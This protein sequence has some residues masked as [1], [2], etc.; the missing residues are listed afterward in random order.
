M[1]NAR[2]SL[3]TWLSSSSPRPASASRNASPQNG[4]RP[5]SSSYLRPTLTSKAQPMARSPSVPSESQL[6]RAPS[7]PISKGWVQPEGNFERAYRTAYGVVMQFAHGA[8]GAE[9]G[10]G[11]DSVYVDLWM[12]IQQAKQQRDEA[13]ARAKDMELKWM[14][15]AR[16]AEYNKRRVQDL[17]RAAKQAAKKYSETIA[18]L[19]EK[20]PQADAAT[21]PL[22]PT[23]H[24]DSQAQTDAPAAVE[25]AQ[26]TQV[27]GSDAA[28]QVA[29]EHSDSQAQTDVKPVVEM[30]QQTPEME[31][32][33]AA[34]QVASEMVEMA[35]QTAEMKGSDAAAQAEPPEQSDSQAQTDATSVVE[36]VEMAQQTTDMEGS[37][38]AVQVA[39]EMVEMAQQTAELKGSDAAVQVATEPTP[40]SDSQA[41]TDGE[42]GGGN[43]PSPV[44]EMV[45]KAQQTAE[46][47]K[48]ASDAA[49]KVA[50]EPAGEVPE[51]TPKVYSDSQAQ[52]D[53]DIVNVSPAVEMVE[54]AQQT[55][56]E[57]RTVPDAAVQGAPEPAGEA[58]EPTP[59]VYSDSQAQTDADIVNV[60]PAVEMVEMAQQTAGEEKTA[61]D[62]AVQVDPEPAC[63]PP[64]PAPKVYSDSQ[65]QTYII[66]VVEK[67]QQT[68]EWENVSAIVSPRPKVKHLGREIEV[69]QKTFED[70]KKRAEEARA[71]AEETTGKS[72]SDKNADLEAAANAAAA[73]DDAERWVKDLQRELDEVRRAEAEDEK[74]KA[75]EARQAA[76][77]A[78][79][80]DSGGKADLEA[81]RKRGKQLER[82]IEVAQKTFEDEKK[83]ADE[84]RVVAEEMTGK[85]DSDKNADLEAAA[86]AAA[87]RDNAER[88]V[89]DLQRELDEVRRAEAKDEKKKADTT[90]VPEKDVPWKTDGPKPA[91]PEAPKTKETAD[92]ISPPN[93]LQRP[94]VQEAATQFEKGADPWGD[95]K[96]VQVSP[97]V[98]DGGS[99][100][101]PHPA[102]HPPPPSPVIVPPKPPCQESATQFEEGIFPPRKPPTPGPGKEKSSQVSPQVVDGGSQTHPHPVPH[103]PPPSPPRNIIIDNRVFPQPSP[104]V[105]PP[106]P[107]APKPSI[108]AGCFNWNPKSWLC[109]IK[110]GKKIGMSSGTGTD[111]QDDCCCCC[112]C[113]W[114]YCCCKR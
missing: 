10:T 85:S 12:Q 29:T 104:P 27:E 37:D 26:Q 60:S 86:N 13:D 56:E 9:P 79:K 89:K 53:A 54:M 71:V 31:G 97:R 36:L 99:Q 17:V 83:R 66:P 46:E 93:L 74:K 73:R 21:E 6:S 59:K 18:K 107:P 2:A 100:T 3:R 41:Q 30:A 70:E 101:H 16:E 48:E 39:T 98:V 114:R 72:D 112:C 32:S 68:A 63:E 113:C 57:E 22:E 105:P 64:E 84:A 106:T 50:P 34:V 80:V 81:P 69:A 15:V 11:V 75:E 49:V 108:F 14:V 92:D 88:W 33:D 47:V 78:A 96:S 28:V 35:Q 94:D 82:E 23:P 91:D 38:A 77:A 67:A 43:D 61:S 51:P 5:R 20:A 102:P 76:E 45:E 25:M 58:P 7:V 4:K 52:T 55:A 44:V 65:A 111:S 24:S 103:P 40:H 42:N 1:Q 8:D 95:D 110:K 62:E 87:A 19:R 109:P 90:V